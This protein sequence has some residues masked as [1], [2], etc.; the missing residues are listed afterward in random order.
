MKTF[1]SLGGRQATPPTN[2]LLPRE[3]IAQLEQVVLTIGWPFN[4]FL[5]FPPQLFQGQI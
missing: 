1:G 5:A 2:E 4:F 3:D